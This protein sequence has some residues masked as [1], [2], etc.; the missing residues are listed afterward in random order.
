[1][2]VTEMVDYFDLLQDKY[3]SPHFTT[4]EK[5]RFLNQ[6]QLDMI[7]QHFPKDGGPLSIEQNAN[8]W[9]LFS[10]LAF[11][12]NMAMSSLGIITKANL[13]TEVGGSVIRLLS[14]WWLDATGTRPVTGPTRHNNWAKY[15]DNVFKV[16]VEKD[17][18]YYETASYYIIAPINTGVTITLT[19]IRYPLPISVSGG[20]TAEISAIGHNEIVGRALELAGVSSRDQ[21]MA[22][23]QQINKV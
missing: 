11:S 10:P 17:P 21:M 16:P 5:E 12:Q 1:M 19:G 23:L 9:M 2:T 3:G 8:L 18:R 7:A 14:M 4:S 15:K 20:Q 22:E 6:A 13:A